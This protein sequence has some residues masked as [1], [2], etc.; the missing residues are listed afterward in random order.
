M[1]VEYRNPTVEIRAHVDLEPDQQW[2]MTHDGAKYTV[3]T[4]YLCSDH[5]HG[6]THL[7]FST[8]PYSHLK[9]DLDAE[10]NWIAERDTPFAGKRKPAVIAGIPEWVA[11]AYDTYL[12][13][14][15]AAR[16]AAR[17][18]VEQELDLVPGLAVLI[19]GEWQ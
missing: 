18:V 12:E 10:G 5:L 2:T 4:V 16:R 8:K 9:A 14:L 19:E 11:G 6:G 15:D 3:E 13:A 17:D 1:A 7:Q